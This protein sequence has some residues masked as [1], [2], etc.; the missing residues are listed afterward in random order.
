M[1]DDRGHLQKDPGRESGHRTDS[2]ADVR[3]VLVFGGGILAALIV[4]L[5]VVALLYW[6]FQGSESE[7][8]VAL[9]T[10]FGSYAPVPP[11]PRLQR[12]PSLD[13]QQMYGRAD[14][15]LSTYG[16]VDKNRRVFHIP[17]E[18]AMAL[19]VERGLPVDTSLSTVADSILVPTESGFV[20]ARRGIPLPT[21]PAYFGSLSAPYAPGSSLARSLGIL[22]A[23][24]SDFEAN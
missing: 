9:E 16:W 2:D 1:S 5:A 11:Q 23:E 22:R 12:D 14:S 24:T 7:P 8:S 3:A 15:I 18:E 4:V 13:L 19:I 20:I 21:A 6:A 17:I 10:P